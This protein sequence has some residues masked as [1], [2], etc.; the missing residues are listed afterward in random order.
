MK[1]DHYQI[2]DV[3]A[4]IKR[5]KIATLGEISSAIGDASARTVFRKLKDLDYIRS[6]SDYGQYYTL[7]GIPKFDRRGLWSFKSVRFSRYGN[8]SE[9]IRVMVDQSDCGYSAGELRDL[10]YVETKLVLRQLIQAE[11][12]IRERI[13]AR[14]VFFSADAKKG[15][16]QRK[17]RQFQETDSFA[18]VFVE[19]SELAADEAKAVVLL[20]ISTLDEKQRRL[21]AGLE[22]LK[23][24]HGGD[25]YIA[26]LFGMDP[27]TVARG[28]IELVQG[29]PVSKQIREQG[30]GRLPVKKNASNHRSSRRDH[31]A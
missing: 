21:Y 11:R 6:Y 7:P 2:K 29:E 20:F 4:F 9:T 3:M 24:G 27:H 28:R 25:G 23:L 16:S 30:G 10:L 14:Y 26:T 18:T 19:N 15:K 31:E 17:I 12:L 8:L 1:T 5:R 22:S 13:D